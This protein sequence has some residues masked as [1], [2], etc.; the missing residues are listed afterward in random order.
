MSAAAITADVWGTVDVNDVQLPV[1][2]GQTYEDHVTAWRILDADV[3]KNC[4]ML[5]AIT[6]RLERKAGGRPGGGP[7]ARQRACLLCPCRGRASFAW[8]F[9][10]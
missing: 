4:W 7:C 8:T 2:L 9:V 1:F 10:A 5:G 6:V 3:Q